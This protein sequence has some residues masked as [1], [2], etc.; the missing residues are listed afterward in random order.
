MKLSVAQLHRLRRFES[1]RLFVQLYI[2][3]ARCR[4]LEL[5]NNALNGSLPAELGSLMHLNKLNLGGNYLS[6]AVPPAALAG[7][8]GMQELDLEVNGFEGPLPVV[9]CDIMT[10]LQHLSLSS[11]RF[12]GPLRLG[13]CS[14]L[15]TINLAFNR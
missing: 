3:C 13:N 1:S 2:W 5:S 12:S 7:W 14:Q 10:D 8:R 9:L 15:V 4:T 11:N 6:G